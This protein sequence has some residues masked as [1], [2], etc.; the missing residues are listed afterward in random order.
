MAF[1]RQSVFTFLNVSESITTIDRTR[2][3]QLRSDYVAVVKTLPKATTTTTDNHNDPLKMIAEKFMLV[4][5][6]INLDHLN[7]CVSCSSLDVAC[8]AILGKYIDFIIVERRNARKTTQSNAKLV[9]QSSTLPIVTV[10]LTKIICQILVKQNDTV[11]IEF[12]QNFL[13]SPLTEITSKRRS[14][15]KFEALS[16]DNLVR[17]YLNSGCT[18]DVFIRSQLLARGDSIDVGRPLSKLPLIES[19]TLV[20]EFD[21]WYFDQLRGL[22]ELN[23][24]PDEKQFP[25][26]WKL[27]AD[28]QIFYTIELAGKQKRDDYENEKTIRNIDRPSTVS[29]ERFVEDVCEKENNGMAAKWL[30]ALRA[31]DIFTYDHLAN[32]KYAEWNELKVLSIN[33]K[34]ILKSYIDHEKQMASDAKSSAPAKSDN[35]RKKSGKIQSESEL[36]ACIHQ[37][38]LYFHYILADEFASVGIPTPVKL[39]ARCVHLS[40]D[41]MRR[42]GFADDGLFDQMKVFFLPLTMIEHDLTINDVQWQNLLRDR[43]REREQLLEKQ[44][45]L[46]DELTEKEDEY[47]RHDDSIRKLRKE[48]HLKRQIS[49]EHNG[50]KYEGF[51]VVELLN[52]HRKRMEQLEHERNELRTQMQTTEDLIENI[53]IGLI[54][55]DDKSSKNTDRDLIKPNRGFIMYGPPGTGKSDIMSKLS[56]RMGVCMVAPPIAAGELNR[57]LVGESERI[58]SDICMRCHRIPYLMCCVSID[59]ID[60]L[61]PKRK[62]NSSDGNIAKLSVLLSVIDGIK[63]VPNL[64]IFCAT[65]RL[66]MMDEAFLRRM[67]GKFF[68]GRP[69]SHARKNILSGI[70]SWHISPSLL[71]SLTMATTNFSGAALRALRRLITV[72]CIDMQ[73][74]NPQ[75]QLDYRTM[76]QLADTTARQY[77]IVIGSETLPTL[78]LRADNNHSFENNQKSISRFNDL[79]NKKNSVYTGKIIV[80]LDVRRIDVEAINIHPITGEREKV[81]C[82]ELLTGSETNIQELL[83]RLTVYGKSRNVQLLQLIDLNLLSAESA[84]D[85]KEKFEILKERLDECAAYR[86]SMIV[87]DL[88]SLIGVNKSEGN[89]SMGRS[90]NLSLINHNVYTYVKDKFKSAYIQS[91]TSNNNNGINKDTVVNEE[92]WSVVVICDPFLL[93]QFCDDV[94]FTRSIS[95]IE[96]EEAEMRRA[97]QPIKCVQCN[98]YYLEQDNKMGVCVHHDGFVYDNLSLTL[99]QWGQQAAIAQLLKEEAEAINQSTTNVMT[100]EQKEHIEPSGM[101]S[102]CKRGKHSSADITLIQWE[103]ACDHN[104]EYQEKRLNLLQSRIQ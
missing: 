52:E 27:A 31:D 3:E 100:S 77:R 97:D 47:Y 42:D 81:V 36:L 35:S 39:D 44:Q 101:M 96:K 58:I 80:N 38:K 30:D 33:G 60:S 99:T 78:L 7:L 90:T 72:H 28:A 103:Y 84:Y 11:V 89:S 32:L 16:S 49:E 88:D 74:I 20:D 10:S 71:E 17:A 8:E 14:Q 61:A 95:E 50:E 54:R 69:S 53:Q 92:K 86:R 65:N 56:T 62:D 68:V 19:I 41:E 9:I 66:H 37:I 15:E 1:N 18:L 40:F 22:F 63:D 51:S 55:Q 82:Q 70:K 45:R 59:E 76:L 29:L 43:L 104:R 64:M 57:P 4:D 25:R 13:L 75:Y 94:A 83:E 91:S 79:P 73:R 26:R 5:D 48:I 85:E 67:S 98:D 93:R 2:L 12:I 34:K 6:P 23:L 21:T 102:G 24:I 87:Y 46:V